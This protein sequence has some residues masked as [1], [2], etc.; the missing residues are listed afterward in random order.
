MHN[1]IMVMNIKDHIKPFNNQDHQKELIHT[2]GTPKKDRQWEY[3][4]K[5]EKFK[6]NLRKKR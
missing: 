6:G 5:I 2:T 1:K 4:K 3:G